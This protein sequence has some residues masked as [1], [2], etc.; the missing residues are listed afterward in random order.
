MELLPEMLDEAAREYPQRLAFQC[1]AQSLTYAELRCAANQLAQCLL[2]NGIRPGDRVAIYMPRCV[3]TAIAVYGVLKCGAV[4]VPIDANA[5]ASGVAGVLKHCQI[6]TIVTHPAMTRLV[7]RLIGATETA[8]SVIGLDSDLPGLAKRLSWHDAGQASDADPGERVSPTDPAYIIHTSGSTGAPKGIVHSHNSGLAYARLSAQTYNITAR[9]VIGS[10]APL[11]TDMS[12]LGYLTAPYVGAGTVI[13]PES[14]T[15][16]PAS[17]CAML[18]THAITIWYSVPLALVQ[19]LSSGLLATT[20]TSRL[21]WILYGGEAFSLSHLRQ[22]AAELPGT[23]ISNVYGPAEVNQCTYYHLP[24]ELL[25]AQTPTTADSVPIGQVWPETHALVVDESDQPV[26]AGQTGELLIASTTRMTG[27]WRRPDLNEK[28]FFIDESE[29]SPRTYYRTGDLVRLR[30]DGLYMLVGRKDRQVKIRG[31]RIELDSVEQAMA[32][33][34]GVSEVGVCTVYLE[35][36]N[37]SVL[38]A[39]V[40]ASDPG[41]TAEHLY[42]HARAALPAAAVPGSIVLV[43]ELPRTT[44]GK[45]DRRQLQQHFESNMGHLAQ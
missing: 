26:A 34:D 18:A 38:A 25:A 9:D 27:Y 45:I 8:L 4:F 23:R 28:A 43:K 31:F 42:E 30:E 11:H 39:A 24:P 14:H 22:L 19:M 7:R 37:T 1:E 2:A 6:S 10:H 12:T 17:L 20:D 35:R 21:R 41:L 13:V 36:E 33:H 5:P 15:R 16:L 40:I 32:E 44:S 3:E 29:S